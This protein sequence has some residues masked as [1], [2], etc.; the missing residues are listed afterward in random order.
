[1]EPQAGSEKTSQNKQGTAQIPTTKD[2]F[3]HIAQKL[4]KHSTD[5]IYLEQEGNFDVSPF[6]G[7]NQDLD[8]AFAGDP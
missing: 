7:N 1:L 4:P 5:F 3:N 6:V 8:N 2:F